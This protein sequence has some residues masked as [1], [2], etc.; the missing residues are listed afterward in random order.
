M[1]RFGNII[2]IGDILVSQDLI[3][4]YFACDYQAC[5]GVCCIVGDSGA[6]MKE[7]EIEGIERSYPKYKHLMS[8]QGCK[9]AETKGFFEIDIEGDIVTPLVEGSCECAYCHFGP[10]GEAMCAIEKMGLRKPVSCSLYPIRVKEFKGGGIGLNLHKWE[11]CQSA[12]EKGKR[13]GI[14]A[15]EFLRKPIIDNFGE[16]FYEALDAAAKYFHTKK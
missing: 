6:P 3:S 12:F 2:Q 13:E 10:A 4:E 14:L 1:S 11:I 8:E 16:E 15:Y 5:K 9:A 7:S